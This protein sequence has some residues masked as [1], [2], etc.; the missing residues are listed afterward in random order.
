MK[1][2]EELEFISINREDEESTMNQTYNVVQGESYDS[3]IGSSFFKASKVNY[4]KAFFGSCNEKN[5]FLASRRCVLSYS[6]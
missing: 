2:A 5:I 3:V 4:K 6:L 1:N